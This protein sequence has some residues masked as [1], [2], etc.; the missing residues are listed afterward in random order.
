MINGKIKTAD[1]MRLVFVLRE[2]RCGLEAVNAA[3]IAQ[4]EAQA[5]QIAARTDPTPVNIV[6]TEVPTGHF[7]QSD[8][9][10]APLTPE[11]LRIEAQAP[12][13][14]PIE[15]L[16][17]DDPA[18][19]PATARPELPERDDDGG[20]FYLNSRRREPQQRLSEEP[21]ESL[22]AEQLLARLSSALAKLE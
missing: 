8:G 11:M 14:P 2:V 17:L 15:K 1:G 10:F 5:V 18:P 13:E 6:V 12:S 20:V 19:D 22:G 16:Q 3:E 7:L 4:A 21:L 9:S